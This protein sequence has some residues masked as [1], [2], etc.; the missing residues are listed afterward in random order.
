ME[1]ICV[2]P[3]GGIPETNFQNYNAESLDKMQMGVSKKRQ[4]WINN[5]S[6]MQKLKKTL[7]L[8]ENLL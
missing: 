4:K 7:K 1:W 6:K 8:L 3:S 5:M 2:I